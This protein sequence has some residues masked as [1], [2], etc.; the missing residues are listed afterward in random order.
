M[1]NGRSEGVANVWSIPQAS[2]QPTVERT[3]NRRRS[4]G[5][6]IVAP[7]APVADSPLGI[8]TSRRADRRITPQAPTVVVRDRSAIANRCV[9][10]ALASVSLVV[11]SP[12]IV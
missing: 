11:L 5:A 1:S 8:D 4:G 10:V 9:N 12:V 2:E 3:P 7:S 6:R